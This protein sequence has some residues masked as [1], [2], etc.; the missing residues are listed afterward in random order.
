MILD[1]IPPQFKLAIVGVALLSS[2]YGGYYVKGKFDLAE[3]ASLQS[4]MEAKRNAQEVTSRTIVRQLQENESRLQTAYEQ[5]SEELKN[6]KGKITVAPCVVTD[7]GARLWDRSSKA[8]MPQDPP[9]TTEEAK[10]SDTPDPQ[11]AGQYN[12]T[13]EDLFDNKLKNDEICNGLRL[14][15]SKIIEWQEKQE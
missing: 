8:G 11:E 15:L 2:F 9:G 3:R 7:T 1:I 4:A 10:G 5:I 12:F 6:A 13:V 14:Q